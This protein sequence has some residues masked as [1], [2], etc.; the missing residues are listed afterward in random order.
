MVEQS[1]APKETLEKLTSEFAGLSETNVAHS[2]LT[3]KLFESSEQ[4][5][6]WF[7]KRLMN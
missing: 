7:Y 3:S 1:E 4:G 5:Q 2:V 6:K